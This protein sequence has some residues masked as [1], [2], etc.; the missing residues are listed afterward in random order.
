M[1]GIWDLSFVRL[2]GFGLPCEIRI[3]QERHHGIAAVISAAW[4]PITTNNATAVATETVNTTSA[5]TSIT[6]LMS[7]PLLL[8]GPQEEGEWK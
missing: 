1:L 7:L 2:P 8:C 6:V 4:G 3:S 5:S